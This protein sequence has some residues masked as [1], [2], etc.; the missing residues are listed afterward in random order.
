M[1][2]KCDDTVSVHE[3]RRFGIKVSQ[4]AKQLAKGDPRVPICAICGDNVGYLMD[5]NRFNDDGSL[6]DVTS[7]YPFLDE[8]NKPMPDTGCNPW[9]VIEEEGARACN[10]CDVTE[11]LPAR[12]AWDPET[13][14]IFKNKLHWYATLKIEPVHPFS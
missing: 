7:L 5:G 2:I 12:F 8:D 14:A 6:V 3:W 1:F 11:V 13:N 9:P 4:Y 10:E